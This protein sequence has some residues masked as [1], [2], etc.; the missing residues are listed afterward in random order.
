MN[1]MPYDELNTFKAMVT[2]YKT[3]PLTN[4][5]KARLRLDIEDYILQ[6]K[7]FSHMFHYLNIH[8]SFHHYYFVF[9]FELKIHL[10][11]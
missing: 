7:M 1:L 10:Q 4:D 11:L 2:E 9:E 3:E 6:N 5:E 8:Q